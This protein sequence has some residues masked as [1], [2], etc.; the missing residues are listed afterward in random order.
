M[1]EKKNILLVILDQLELLRA[2]FARRCNGYGI[3]KSCIS[4]EEKIIFLCKI[5]KNSDIPYCYYTEIITAFSKMKTTFTVEMYNQNI[6]PIIKNLRSNAVPK[7][8][9]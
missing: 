3:N 2:E 6:I 9:N 5:L 8:K 1:E 4:I 7:I